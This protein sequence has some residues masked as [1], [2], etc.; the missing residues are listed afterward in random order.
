MEEV[1]KLTLGIPVGI[2]NGNCHW[3]SPL[4]IPLAIAIGNCKR[5]LPLGITIG[6]CNWESAL[7]IQLGVR[8]KPSTDVYRAG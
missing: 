7:G 5:E 8:G 4:A 2:A 6:N 3:E 1:T